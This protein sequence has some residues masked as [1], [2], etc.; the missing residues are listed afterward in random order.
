[1]LRVVG[2]GIREASRVNRGADLPDPVVDDVRTAFAGIDFADAAAQVIVEIAAG[3][4]SP[5]SGW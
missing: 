3:D 1:V 4:S 5:V 2:D